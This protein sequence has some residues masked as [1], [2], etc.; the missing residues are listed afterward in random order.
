MARFDPA[1]E[2]EWLDEQE[3]NALEY[4]AAQGGGNPDSL[5]VQWS[6]PPYVSIWTV[7]DTGAAKTWVICGDLPTDFLRDEAVQDA[8]SAASAFGTR[9]LDV[10]AHLSQGKQ[11][12]EISIGRGLSAG[13]LRELG[14]LLRSRAELLVQWSEDPSY[15]EE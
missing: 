9:W 3:A 12:P 11:H 15:W 14:D 6:L 2:M 10:S 1:D 13:K 8:R 7:P 4:L 5:E